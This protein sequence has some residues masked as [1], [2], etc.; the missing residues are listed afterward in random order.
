D[1]THTLTLHDAL[2]IWPELTREKFIPFSS[3]GQ[4][5]RFYRTGDLARWTANG[6]IE[7]LGRIDS[8]VK[9]RGFRVEL[10]EI[11]SVMMESL[12]VSRSEEHTSE[13]QSPD[14]L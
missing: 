2:P 10:S 5:R 7:F 11:E 14:H 13:L 8:Q 1:R 6:E 4:S 12:E 9:I 3:D